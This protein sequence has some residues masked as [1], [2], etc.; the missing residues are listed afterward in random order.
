MARAVVIRNAPWKA[1][2]KPALATVVP[3]RK[4]ADAVV[5]IA[6][7]VTA[8]PVSNS[9]QPVSIAAQELTPRST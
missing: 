3:A 7:N 6:P 8:T 5:A 4:A 1:R 9:R 2:P